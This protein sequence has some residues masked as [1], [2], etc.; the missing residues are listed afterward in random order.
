MSGK[1]KSKRAIRVFF[2]LCIGLSIFLG[3]LYYID[4][5]IKNQG[6]ETECI[7]DYTFREM[8]GEEVFYVYACPINQIAVDGQF[9]KIENDIVESQA[10]EVLKSGYLY[11]NKENRTQTFFPEYLSEKRGIR[12]IDDNT[13]LEICPKILYENQMEVKSEV[14]DYT[15]VY[16]EKRKVV[17]YSGIWENIDLVFYPVTLGIKGEI[18]F[19]KKSSSEKVEFLL[20]GDIFTPDV[21]CEEYITLKDEDGEIKEIFFRPFSKNKNDFL[22]GEHNI[23]QLKDEEGFQYTVST[24]KEFLNDEK[25]EYPVKTEVSFYLYQTKQ[26]D[27]SIKSKISGNQYLSNCLFVGNEEARGEMVSYI[28]FESDIFRYMDYQS[29]KKAEYIITNITG[30]NEPIDINAYRVESEWGSPI[31]SWEDQPLTNEKS[32][33][34]GKSVGNTYIFDI[35]EWVKNWCKFQQGKGKKEDDNRLGFMLKAANPDITG[36]KIFAS[37]DNLVCSP[38]LKITLK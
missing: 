9:R 11:Q 7:D 31:I 33:L 23:E 13:S 14:M 29:I 15:D 19:T 35:T 1:I 2:L 38:Y 32:A 34:K 36:Y 4:R 22:F 21:S 25:T 24:A 6:Q 3:V 8:N 18:V 5:Q 26:A 12:V 30:N 17:C 27:S 10:D 28:R 16:G 20:S 37:G